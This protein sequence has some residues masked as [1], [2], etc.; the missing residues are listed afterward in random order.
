LLR[1]RWRIANASV[2]VRR[3]RNRRGVIDL[4]GDRAPK[5]A[6]FSDRRTSCFAVRLCIIAP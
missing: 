3:S 6:D 1:A 2:A 4:L 5:G